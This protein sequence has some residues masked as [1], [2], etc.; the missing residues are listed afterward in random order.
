MSLNIKHKIKLHNG[1]KISITSEQFNKL[2]NKIDL[3]EIKTSENR[4]TKQYVPFSTIIGYTSVEE[5]PT[6]NSTVDTKKLAKLIA[7]KQKETR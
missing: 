4:K 2:K 6:N 7:K 1:K 5:Q 3:M